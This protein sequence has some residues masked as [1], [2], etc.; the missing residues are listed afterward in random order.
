MAF[1]G[2]FGFGVANWRVGPRQSRDSERLQLCKN[3]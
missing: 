1:L 2:L 3:N